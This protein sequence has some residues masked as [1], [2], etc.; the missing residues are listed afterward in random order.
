VSG[1]ADP[2]YSAALSNGEVIVVRHRDG[3]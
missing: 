3:K 1:I 2:G